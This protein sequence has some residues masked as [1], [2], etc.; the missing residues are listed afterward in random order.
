MPTPQDFICLFLSYRN[1]AVSTQQH[2][3]YEEN[4]ETI[5]GNPFPG[6]G[7]IR[8][9]SPVIFLK[10]IQKG[11]Y[12]KVRKAPAKLYLDNQSAY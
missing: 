6:R 2:L 1:D 10:D 11:D 9:P 5:Q 4:H 8:W 12:K 7:Y 3:E